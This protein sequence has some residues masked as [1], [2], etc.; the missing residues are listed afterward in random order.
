MQAEQFTWYSSPQ[1]DFGSGQHRRL[2]RNSNFA[3]PDAY[4]SQRR[5]KA[6]TF[7]QNRH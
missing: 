7:L 2:S 1:L 6:S 5:L 4:G 3:R